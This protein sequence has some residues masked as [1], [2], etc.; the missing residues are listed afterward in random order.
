MKNVVY[1]LMAFLM[2]VGVPR[3]SAAENAV[4]EAAPYRFSNSFIFVE[5]GITFA[6][7]P[8]GE[9][10]F[11]IDRQVNLQAGVRLGGAAVTFNSGFNYNPFVQYDDY[12]AVI[13][14]EHVPVFYDYFGRVSAIGGVNITYR[15]GRVF[16]MGGMRVFYNPMG[17]YDYHVGFI[18]PFNRVY[19]FRPFH[20][21][22][23]RPA[24]GFCM[25][26]RHPYRRFYQPVRYTYYRPY[27][28]NVRRAYARVG[29]QHRYQPRAERS[30]I[31]RNDRR[32]A[33]RS[34]AR[35][36]REAVGQASRS[37][38]SVVRSDR[39]L[40]RVRTQSRTRSSN[41]K[42]VRA[43]ENRTR[44]RVATRERNSQRQEV[45]SRST[46][47][48][49]KLVARERKPQRQEVRSRS[50]MGRSKVASRAPQSKRSRG[51]GQISKATGRT[52][53]VAQS[54]KQS[55]RDSGARVAPQRQERS[56]GRSG[57]SSRRE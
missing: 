13:Q 32:V 10:D 50:T 35:S 40:D 46:S 16:R 18:N 49:S 14:V 23:V 52:Q 24:L 45:R 4:A 7:Y 30:R 26:Y 27:R 38:R 41:G 15:H 55:R 51:N 36:N 22:F 25:V 34:T 17:F 42:V 2:G 29:N 33:V 37:S 44:T 57:R 43:P 28:N 11:Y 47:G 19:V 39:G 31:Y 56:T 54:G 53:R 8:D 21:F 9:F 1:F 3:A 20:R 6:V 5:N 12:G 48:R